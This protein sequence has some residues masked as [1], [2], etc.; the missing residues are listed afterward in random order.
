M[1]GFSIMKKFLIGII[2]FSGI[3]F[4][5]SANEHYKASTYNSDMKKNMQIF[6]QMYEILSNTSEN[7]AKLNGNRYTRFSDV[8]NKNVIPSN[9]KKIDGGFLIP[10]NYEN[11][12]GKLR[13][14]YNYEVKF[15][16][17]KDNCTPVPSVPS[18][19]NASTACGKVVVD[20]NGFN[21]GT[22]KYFSDKNTLQPKERGIL[23]MYSNG[24][25][26]SP[27]SVEDVIL[28]IA[29]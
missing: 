8:L 13:I 7:A 10:G 28:M 27:N 2:L 21:Y 12:N 14:P 24:I 11:I 17:L 26:A 23:W 18:K 25:K 19:I 1:R 22:N 4:S 20:V 5:V 3:G 16:K 9:A 6:K 15:H 29:K